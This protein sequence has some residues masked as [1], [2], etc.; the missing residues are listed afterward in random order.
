M[1]DNE[2]TVSEN[3]EFNLLC[4]EEEVG[5][6]STA[7]ASATKSMG[8]IHVG[9]QEEKPEAA[10]N[11]TAVSVTT[12]AIP[13]TELSGG[14]AE[15]EE[16][17]TEVSKEATVAPVVKVEVAAATVVKEEAKGSKK[18]KSDTTVTLPSSSSNKKTKT[19]ESVPVEGESRGLLPD[20]I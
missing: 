3:A 12:V 6:E 1:S 2:K 18:R 17:D 14:V 7:L 5:Q 9:D 10:G 20:K 13:T 15:E 4:G 11:T 19:S 16:A 8:S